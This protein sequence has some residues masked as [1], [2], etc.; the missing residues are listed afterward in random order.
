MPRDALR[1]MTRRSKSPW[2]L[3]WIVKP[4]SLVGATAASLTLALIVV[5]VIACGGGPPAAPQQIYAQAGEKMTGLASYHVAVEKRPEGETLAWEYD[6][7]MPDRLR[8]TL[9]QGAETLDWIRIGDQ[10][11]VRP[12]GSPDFFVGPPPRDESDETVPEPD[13]LLSALTAE[14]DDLTSLGEEVVDGVSTHHLQGIVDERDLRLWDPLGFEIEWAVEL[15]AGS[16]D[17]TDRVELWIGVNDSL[18][19]RYRWEKSADEG[20]ETTTLL[21]SRFDDES[22]SIVSPSNPKPVEEFVELLARQQVQE[23]LGQA[24]PN[25]LQCLRQLLGDAAFEEL[26]AG[27]RGMTKEEFADSYKCHVSSEAQLQILIEGLDAQEE[28]CL[29]GAVGDARF[30][31][32][33][34]GG[35]YLSLTDQDLQ[36]LMAC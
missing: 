26:K 27:T 4:L 13:D 28:A 12:P 3:A 7:V 31:E 32:L 33:Q 15:M 29:R 14:I 11:Y 23:D 24:G 22:I 17:L 30:E 8:W 20:G 10:V 9:T 35:L 25:D 16:R 19:H 18:V 2:G 34:E 1:E 6:I 21:F 36:A 5:A